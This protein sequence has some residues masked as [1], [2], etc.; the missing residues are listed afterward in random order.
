MRGSSTSYPGGNQVDGLP[1]VPSNN[2]S[3]QELVPCCVSVTCLGDFDPKMVLL[4]KLLDMF[5]ELKTIF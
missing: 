2:G 4:L 5:R 1:P 3:D